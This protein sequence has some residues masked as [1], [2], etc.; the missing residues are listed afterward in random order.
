MSISKPSIWTVGGSVLARS[1]SQILKNH[2][3]I[4][5]LS[6]KVEEVVQLRASYPVPVPTS[7]ILMLGLVRGMLG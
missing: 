6:L 4:N 1:M 7:A 5:A 2:Q 3:G